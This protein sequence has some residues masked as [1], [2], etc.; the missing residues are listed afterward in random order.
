MQTLFGSED[1]SEG[2]AGPSGAGPVISTLL[3]AEPETDEDVPVIFAFTFL[4]HTQSP[5][6]SVLDFLRIEA[7]RE[8]ID[9]V[10]VTILASHFAQ[11][12]CDNGARLCTE[13]NH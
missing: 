8:T 11:A 2:K 4:L 9:D 5:E 3:S 6:K 12:Y 13:L 10:L 7:G 1:N